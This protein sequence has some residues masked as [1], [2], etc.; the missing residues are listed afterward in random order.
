MNI[1]SGMRAAVGAIENKDRRTEWKLQIIGQ[2][3]NIGKR[4]RKSLW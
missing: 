2:E 1:S 4:N 3:K